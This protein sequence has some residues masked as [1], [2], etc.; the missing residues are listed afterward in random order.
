[1]KK[2]LI[3]AFLMLLAIPSSAEEMRILQLYRNILSHSSSVEIPKGDDIF[4]VVNETTIGA[5]TEAE[6]T[7]VLPLAFRCAYSTDVEVRKDGFVFLISTITRPDSAKILGSYIDDLE[8]LLATGDTASR[9]TIYYVLGSMKPKLP[10]KAA[11]LLKKH[12]RDETNSSAETL[13]IAASL[14]KD[15]PKDTATVHEVLSAV[16]MRNDSALADGTLR[17]MGLSKCNVPEA[18]DFMARGLQSR[19]LVASAV[20]AVSRLDPD[21]RRNFKQQLEQ[22]ASDPSAP[23]DVRGQAKIA[24]AAHDN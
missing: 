18:L 11:T 4:G 20:D 21:D 14:I 13:T 2:A 16:S 8:K 17:Q 22:V 10:P 7:A 23:V 3:T 1:M 24:A 9:R 6:I 5:S 19:E 15:A 12:L